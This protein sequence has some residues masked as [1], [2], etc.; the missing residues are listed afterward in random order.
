M[1]VGSIRCI[2]VNVT[3]LAIGEAFWSEVT[4]LPVLGSNYTGR[5]SYLGNQEPWKHE[6]ILQLV[7]EPKG[8]E[9]NRCHLDLSVDDVDEA[10]EKII[11]IG[12]R[13]KKQPSIY[14]R[15]GSF[16]GK[17][18]VIDWAVMTDPFANEFCLV[19][20]LSEDERRAAEAATEARTDQEWRI[21]AGRTSVRK[22]G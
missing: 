12:G 8:A 18:P 10:I 16:P 20:D 15:P 2:V 13:V 7:H 3:D 4:G 19:S 6:M 22:S 17:P 21:A 5:F 1:S 11:S 14:P 9:A